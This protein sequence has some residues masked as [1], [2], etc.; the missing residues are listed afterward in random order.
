MTRRAL[1]L[2][3]D[4]L[5]LYANTAQ[6]VGAITTKAREQKIA[7]AMFGWSDFPL[8][9]GVFNLYFVPAVVDYIT[10]YEKRRQSAP[11]TVEQG[12]CNAT[13]KRP[14]YRGAA[15]PPAK[16]RTG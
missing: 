2:L 3:I 11:T 15:A 6:I 9:S 1:P 10:E 13:S 7:A 12:P 8:P 14:A 16:F 4:A 5:P